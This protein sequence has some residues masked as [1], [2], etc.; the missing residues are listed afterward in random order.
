VLRV[1]PSYFPQKRKIKTAGNRVDC[2]VILCHVVRLKS[3]WVS[4]GDF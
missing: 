1:L 2:A 3:F 4:K